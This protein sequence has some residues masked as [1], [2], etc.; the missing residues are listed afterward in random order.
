MGW[1]RLGI[2]QASFSGVLGVLL[3]QTGLRLVEAWV[4][5]TTTILRGLLCLAEATLLILSLETIEV[6]RWNLCS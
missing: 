3:W 2:V 4:P 6:A 5:E 1:C